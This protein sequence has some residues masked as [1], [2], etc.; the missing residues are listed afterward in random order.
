MFSPLFLA[1]II[2][3]KPKLILLFQA[4]VTPQKRLHFAEF[5]FQQIGR[6]RDTQVGKTLAGK[7]PWQMPF[8]AV[9]RSAQALMRVVCVACFPVH[10]AFV[11]ESCVLLLPALESLPERR[12]SGIRQGQR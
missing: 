6:I 9:V 1:E 5:F 7:Q 8:Q 3:Y 2:F 11:Q 4:P 12:L 10:T